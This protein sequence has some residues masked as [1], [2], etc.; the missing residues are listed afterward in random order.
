MKAEAVKAALTRAG[1]PIHKEESGVGSAATI[2]VAL[3]GRADLALGGDK[4]ALHL[5]LAGDRL[6][7][8]PYLAAP[9]AADPPAPAPLS[10][11]KPDDPDM[12]GSAALAD[13]DASIE[14]KL[15][16]ITADKIVVGPTQLMATVADGAATVDL[17]I[18]EVYGGSV[19]L[20]AGLRGGGADVP[21]NGR[22]AFE[23][24][25][26]GTVLRT[27]F[28]VEGFGGAASG[29]FRV[30]SSGGKLSELQRRLEANGQFAIENAEVPPQFALLTANPLAAAKGAEEGPSRISGVL[31]YGRDSR[32]ADM[33]WQRGDDIVA[34]FS[35]FEK[36]KN[37]RET[38]LK[39]TNQR[40]G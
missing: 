4:P 31:L 23:A 11:G 25:D 34:E 1:L 17:D 38:R 9:G 36:K 21:I 18:A 20:T 30:A 15:N 28:G 7:L 27:M 35:L 29:E 33:Q 40:D 3:D 16:A 13:F 8:T 32:R 22:L 14:L 6:D 26:P 24:I 37:K 5:R 10:A 12:A 39:R 19:K 2:G